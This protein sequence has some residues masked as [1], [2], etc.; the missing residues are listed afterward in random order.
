MLASTPLWK[1]TEK[2]RFFHLDRALQLHSI[3]PQKYKHPK[4]QHWVMCA[5]DTF[6][7]IIP[8]TSMAETQSHLKT[9]TVKGMLGLT[10][11]CQDCEMWF[12]FP[13]SIIRSLTHHS[14]T[15][16]SFCYSDLSKFNTASIPVLLIKVFLVLSIYKY[17]DTLTRWELTGLS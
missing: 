12:Q 15:G 4:R 16:I 11:V 10:C 8:L 6:H 14:T 13:P 3:S 9:E 5:S 1:H 7:P 2:S 17:A